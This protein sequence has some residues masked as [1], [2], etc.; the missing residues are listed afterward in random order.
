MIR[1]PFTFQQRHPSPYPS[2][3]TTIF[4]EWYFDHYDEIESDREYLPVFWTGYYVRVDYGQ[5]KAK[6]GLLQAWLDGLD[7]K[8]KYYT[9]IQYDNGII[10]D[11]SHLDIKVFSMSGGQTDY[12]LPLIALPHTFEFNFKRRPFVAN[13]V[14]KVTHPI[15]EH[16]I[17]AQ[18]PGNYILT[19]KH[20]MGE[21]CRIIASSTFTLCPRGF[22]PTSFRIQEAMQFGSIP[23]YIS[24][25]FVIPHG[26][27]FEDYGVIINAKDAGR[28]NEILRSIPQEEI[29]H[30]QANIPGIYEKYFTYEG[31]QKA[32]R[33][34]VAECNYTAGRLSI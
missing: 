18:A 19:H 22:G 26:I 14:G 30:K 13:F 11:L 25:E 20:R 12:P 33:K 6:M 5:D 7:R 24:D 15:R 9:I 10:H 3:N 34:A 1:V 27:P 17:H 4:E 31:N 28:I 32:I 8:K 2:D 21:Y 16:V 29:R 23:V